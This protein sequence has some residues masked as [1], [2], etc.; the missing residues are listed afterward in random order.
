MGGRSPRRVIGDY[1]TLQRGT[2][3][4]SRLLG[5][6]G[7]ALLG[8]AS[9]G[10]NGGFRNDSLQ[11]YGG[12]CSQKLLVQPGDLYLSLKDVTQSADLLGA[13]ARLPLDAVPGRLTQD[14]VKLQPTSPD[15]PVEY[16]YWLLRT[17]QYRAYCRAHATGTTNLGL[18]REDFL[19][20]SA[21]EPTEAQLRF[22]AVL[23]RIERKIDLN[24]RMSA[25]LG[26]MARAL[27]KSWFVD[28]DPTRAKVE[29]RDPGLPKLLA[30]LFPARLIESELGEIPEG[31]EV[32]TLADHYEAVKGVSYKGSGL[33]DD[34]MP[35]HNLNSVYEGGG[36]KYE[37]IKYYSGGYAE[38]HT[39]APGDVI[40]ANTEQGHDRLLI[41]YAALVPACLGGKGIVS[42]HIYRLRPKAKSQLTAAYL[43]WLLNSPQ[44]HDVVSGYAN[45]TTVNMLPI[46]GVQKPAIVRPPRGD[47]GRVS[48]ALIQLD[49][50]FE[51]LLKASILPRGGRIR[52]KRAKETIGFDACV[53]RSLSDGKIKYLSEEQA[54]VLQTING[55]R[56]AAQ[57]HLLDISE[58]QLYVHVQ[59]GV[60]LFRDMLSQVFGQDLSRH[61]PRRVLP[62]ST[63]PPTDLATLFDSETAEIRKLLRPGRR[64]RLE[65]LARLRPL[66][67]LDSTIRGEKGQ[68]SDAELRKLGKDVRGGKQWSDVFR[69]AASVEIAA[70]GTGPRISLRLAKKAS[71]RW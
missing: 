3:Y 62:V 55:L 5:L 20:F 50:G 53:R 56:D 24:R 34:G 19:S 13:V 68:P 67:I 22:A 25:T 43:C 31:W 40:V 2:T 23:A 37:G 39:V 15:V 41:G 48:G 46:D 59:S 38:R 70:E 10:R 52:D 21:P 27:F 63:A 35:L 11:T 66:A 60:T 64:R 45:G 42:H 8:L 28:F 49:H 4:S 16:L 47:R 57:H 17:P 71:C 36:Y 18:A 44:M 12:E 65:A 54:L 6:P 30:D 51:M 9:I 29:G 61:L 7:P 14:T 58:G 1:F 69:G 33:G 26:A 32:E